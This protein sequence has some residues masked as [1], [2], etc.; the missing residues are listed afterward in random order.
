MHIIHVFMG[1]FLHNCLLNLA[2]CG[3]IMCVKKFNLRAF[4]PCSR[5]IGIPKTYLTESLFNVLSAFQR[6]TH[7]Q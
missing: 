2:D 4:S 5:S 3:K 1:I 7:E 6:I